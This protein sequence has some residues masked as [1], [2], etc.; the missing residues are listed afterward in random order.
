MFC[1]STLFPFSSVE[2]SP[3]LWHIRRRNPTQNM[4][5]ESRE[6]E[7]EEEEEVERNRKRRRERIRNTAV[8]AFHVCL[9][10][11]RWKSRTGCNYIVFKCA[12]K[13]RGLEEFD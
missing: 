10:K 8:V 7:E 3:A 1:F 5:S 6:R 4:S 12:I 11:G 9:F 13:G 2:Q